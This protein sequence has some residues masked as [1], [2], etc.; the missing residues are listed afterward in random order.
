MIQLTYISSAAAPVTSEHVTRILAAS[1]R[2]NKATGI[3]G[4][5]LYDG[6]RFLQTLEGDPLAISNTFFRIKADNTHRGIVQ[7]SSK[8]IDKRSFCDWAMAAHWVDDSI[9]VIEQI[10]AL[11]VGVVDANLRETFRSFARIRAVS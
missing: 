5:L 6:R 10:N 7:I 4:L 3:T 1:I 11:T 9:S 2:R 8:D